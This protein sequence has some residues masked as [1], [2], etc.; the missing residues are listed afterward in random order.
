M[1][2]E[3][4]KSFMADFGSPVIFGRYTTTALF[5]Q[6]AADVISN[7]VQSN[8]YRI[9]YPAGDLPGLANGSELLIGIGPG[10]GF[11]ETGTR[12][13]YS[14]RC[15]L[16][17]SATFKVLGVPGKIDDGLFMEARLQKL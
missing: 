6:P 2:L 10:W 12:L 4:P 1:F 14:G 11:D 5:D 9:E 7:R 16:P 15:H 8:Q 3:D 17:E 13:K